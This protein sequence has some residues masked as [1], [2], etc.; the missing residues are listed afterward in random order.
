MSA[1][2]VAAIVVLALVTLAST[3]AVF[4]A[5]RRGFVEQWRGIPANRRPRAIVAG[6]LTA[7]WVVA[8]ATL[9]IAEPWGDRTVLYVVAISGGVVLVLSL[10][11]V[12]FDALRH[13]RRPDPRRR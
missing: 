9:A 13:L 2:G 6:V 1:V 5:L 10:T 4:Y 12:A 11:A 7:L 8:G 3:I